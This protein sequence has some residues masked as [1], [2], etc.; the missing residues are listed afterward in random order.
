MRI[1][2][3]GLVRNVESVTVIG[4]VTGR[5]FEPFLLV[6]AGVGYL[7]CLFWFVYFG[8]FILVCLFWAGIYN[9]CGVVNIQCLVFE[10]GWY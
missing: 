10:L 6:V 9:Y 4:S 2:R 3:E 7:V 8:V 1:M 5:G